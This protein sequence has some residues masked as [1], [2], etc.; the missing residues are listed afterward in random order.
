MV[1]MCFELLTEVPY[2]VD[3]RPDTG[4]GEIYFHAKE[5]RILF[6]FCTECNQT[7]QVIDNSR[8]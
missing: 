4:F 1:G 8:E 6:D 7:Q 3:Y 5:V 2:F